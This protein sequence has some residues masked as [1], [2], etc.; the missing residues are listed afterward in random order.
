MQQVIGKKVTQKSRA[1]L[2]V[3]RHQTLGLPSVFNVFV[4]AAGD[5]HGHDG[6]VPRGDEHYGKTQ[7]HPQEGQ[8]PAGGN[9]C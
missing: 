8:S 2:L 3:N 7:A 1:N 9:A 5:D 6:V 4:D